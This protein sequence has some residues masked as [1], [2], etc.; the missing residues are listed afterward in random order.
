MLMIDILIDDRTLQ[1]TSLGR[2]CCETA[3]PMAATAKAIINLKDDVGTTILIEAIKNQCDVDIVRTIIKHGADVSVKSNDGSF[4]LSAAIQSRNDEI[5][6]ELISAGANVKA[7]T[8]SGSSTILLDAIMRG[9]TSDTVKAI[10]NA[11]AD[12]NAKTSDG[13]GACELAL[14]CFLT[15]SI[16]KRSEDGAKRLP[17]SVHMTTLYKKYVFNQFAYEKLLK[18]LEAILVTL[19]DSDCLHPNFMFANAVNHNGNDRNGNASN[20]GIGLLHLAALWLMPEL[21]EKLLSHGV[22]MSLCTHG[23]H[24]ALHIACSNTEHGDTRTHIIKLL[25]DHMAMMNTEN[26]GGDHYVLADDNEN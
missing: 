23:G 21:L 6:Q 5:V 19:L 25:L 14:M 1:K 17:S 20:R 9:L 4:A 12:A 15:D 24:T 26:N 13:V 18:R 11:G 16:T 2:Y 22:D 3:A 8:Q 10:I 7:I